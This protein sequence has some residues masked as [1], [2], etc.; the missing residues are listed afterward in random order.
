[1]SYFP[2]IGSATMS[3]TL[4]GNFR[5]LDFSGRKVTG[6]HCNVVLKQSL[7]TFLTSNFQDFALNFFL[8]PSTL[9]GT[10]SYP[11]KTTSVLKIMIIGI[12]MV[13]NMHDDDKNS[14]YLLM[15]SFR[16]L[17]KKKVHWNL[18][19]KWMFCLFSKKVGIQAMSPQEESNNLVQDISHHSNWYFQSSNI[20]CSYMIPHKND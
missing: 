13:L 4:G 7:V 19:K 14:T 10:M 5:M 18:W 6:V 20:F 9:P 1:M 16:N 3:C 11:V 12:D 17:Y 8:C 2:A 15:T